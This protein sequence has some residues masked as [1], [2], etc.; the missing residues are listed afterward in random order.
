MVPLSPMTCSRVAALFLPEDRD[1]AI[2]MLLSRCGE[3]L[4]GMAQGS[5]D[6]IERIRFAALRRSKGHL[7]EL[8][9]AVALAETDWRD[10][11]VAAGFDADPTAH[12]R[13]TLHLSKAEFYSAKVVSKVLWYLHD[14]DLPDRLLWARLRVFA[15][16]SADSAF[17]ADGPLYGFDREIFASF[18][19][20]EDEYR[21][22]SRF[23]A[24]DER[25]L[26]IR[27]ADIQPPEWHDADDAPFEYLGIY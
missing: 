11:L 27:V 10:L 15:D 13:W 3:G 20:T 6:D 5:P 1:A 9:H 8:S 2:A 21:C 26:G 7:R 18:I 17:S 4:P 14:P 24:E 12:L 23:D 22:V 19:L 16:G 25:E